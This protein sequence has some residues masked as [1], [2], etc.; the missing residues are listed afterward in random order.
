MIFNPLSLHETLCKLRNAGPDCLFFNFYWKLH[1]KWERI[2][3][4][5][6][7]TSEN[8]TSVEK[9]KIQKKL[10]TLFALGFFSSYFF[11]FFFFS[12]FYC[13]ILIE[14]KLKIDPGENPLNNS[15]P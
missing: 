12:L 9:E 15:A 11:S 10:N 4:Q 13:S 7:V 6:R 1:K 3:T 14:V 5:L 2:I 8:S